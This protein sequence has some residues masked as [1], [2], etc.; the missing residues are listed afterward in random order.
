MT[1]IADVPSYTVRRTQIYLD[2]EQDRRLAEQARRLGRTKS[3]LIREA[4]DAYLA[5]DTKEA[6]LARFKAAADAAFG[7][8][9]YLPED[10]VEQLRAASVRASDELMRRWHGDDYQA[11]WA[12]DD[13]EQAEA[14]E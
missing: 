6:R 12:A 2:Q 13:A 8:A 7:I 14:P 5:G 10:Y 11:V 1:Y 4:I 3:A 9:P